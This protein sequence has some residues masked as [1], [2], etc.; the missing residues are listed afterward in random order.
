MGKRPVASRVYKIAEELLEPGEVEHL[1]LVAQWLKR[2]PIAV[3]V[4][5]LRRQF[6]RYKV[7]GEYRVNRTQLA[8][9]EVLSWPTV[10]PSVPELAASSETLEWLAGQIEGLPPITRKVVKRKLAGVA[11]RDIAAELGCTMDNVR[12]HRKKGFGHLGKAHYERGVR[13]RMPKISSTNT[14]DR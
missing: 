5:E 7:N 3:V 13:D 2:P 10:G 4:D 9:D 1:K 6:G 12:F 8:G 11:S 14:C